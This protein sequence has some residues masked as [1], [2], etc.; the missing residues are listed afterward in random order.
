MRERDAGGDRDTDIEHKGVPNA[1]VHVRRQQDQQRDGEEAPGPARF[2]SEER[3]SEEDQHRGRR[4]EEER[5]R[6][7]SP[8]AGVPAVAE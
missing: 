6:E 5:N 3:K 1:E 8:V 4:L 2:A 7:E